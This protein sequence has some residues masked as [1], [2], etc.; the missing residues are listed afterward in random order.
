[1]FKRVFQSRPPCKPEREHLSFMKCAPGSPS[2]QIA[3]RL[4]SSEIPRQQ[5]FRRAW[6]FACA[7]QRSVDQH[8]A[9]YRLNRAN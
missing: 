3:L 5:S 4:P 2:M 9:E 1:M 7:F 6:G 8:K